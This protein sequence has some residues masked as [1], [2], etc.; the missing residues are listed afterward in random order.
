MENLELLIADSDPDR[1]NNFSSRLRVQGYQ[2]EQSLEGF[3]TIHLIEENK[4]A[5]LILMGNFPDM[6]GLEILSLARAAKSKEELPIIFISNGKDQE[7]VL[8]A[9]EYG[10]NDII[11]YSDKCFASLMEKLKKYVKRKKEK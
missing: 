3:Q 5:A 7:E 9:F 1:R 8:T 4:Y 11:V 10:A 6:R 2:I